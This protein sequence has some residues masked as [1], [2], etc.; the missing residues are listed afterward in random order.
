MP[1]K[2]DEEG[3]TPAP[4]AGN[5]RYLSRDLQEVQMTFYYSGLRHG[6]ERGILSFLGCV[7]GALNFF[8]P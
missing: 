7:D 6:Q 2:S 4:Y 1:R 3:I 8:T 5:Q